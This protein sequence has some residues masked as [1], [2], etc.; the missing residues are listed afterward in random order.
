MV[1]PALLECPNVL[2]TPHIG[3]ATP[4]TRMSMV[5]MALANLVAALQGK[6]PSNVV[7]G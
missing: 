1:H 2:L 6:T 3:S 7:S 4:D 5:R